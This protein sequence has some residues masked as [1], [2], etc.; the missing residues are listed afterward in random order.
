MYVLPGLSATTTTA[1]RPVMLRAPAELLEMSLPLAREALFSINWTFLWGM[2]RPQFLHL[3]LSPLWLCCCRPLLCLQPGPLKPFFLDTA[4]TSVDSGLL[5]FW[6][7]PLLSFSVSMILSTVLA[8]AR[9]WAGVSVGFSL[10]NRASLTLL[11]WLWVRNRNLKNS[12]EFVKLHSLAISFSHLMKS[13]WFL[14]PSWYQ[15]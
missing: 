14:P 4:S 13:P 8:I 2:S 1:L 11:F 6:R 10:S 3:V 12:S 15:F 7:K 9:H 5:M